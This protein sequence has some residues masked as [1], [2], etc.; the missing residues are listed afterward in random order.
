MEKLKEIIKGN[1]V[2]EAENKSEQKLEIEILDNLIEKAEF[3]AIPEVLIDAERL[4][5]VL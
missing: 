3:E 5:N 1:L 2:K 4:K